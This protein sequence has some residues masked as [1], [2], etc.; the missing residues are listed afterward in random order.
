M[1]KMK[2][3]KKI[4]LCV[5]SLILSLS[6]SGCANRVKALEIPSNK[7]INTESISKIQPMKNFKVETY[8]SNYMNMCAFSYD[9]S[10][11]TFTDG[12]KKDA[13]VI[14]YGK[15]RIV[16][17]LH[18]QINKQKL[19]YNQVAAALEKLPTILSEN[20]IEIQLLDYSNVLDK[21]WEKTYNMKNFMSYAT[22]GSNK[23]YF[24]ANSQLN[25]NDKRVSTALIHESGH[26]LDDTIS[27]DTERL[28]NSKE[29][30]DIMESDFKDTNN[31][32][33]YCSTY[34]KSSTSNVEDF[35]EA[36]VGYCTD[37]DKFTKEYPNRSSK[38]E[39]LFNNK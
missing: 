14:E 7:M 8:A 10:Q 24:Y 29:W 26:I 15:F 20:I 33:L 25:Q 2:Y 28:S 11:Y 38:L 39:K 27:N 1:L 4:S 16:Q 19:L 5:C 21:Y 17:P 30:S 6:L 3:N 36:V 18:S 12:I 23:I 34:S 32:G 22:G 37:K 13:H 35:A 31:F 9:I